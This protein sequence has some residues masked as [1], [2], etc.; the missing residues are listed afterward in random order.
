MHPNLEFDGSKEN[1]KLYAQNDAFKQIELSLHKINN[2][3]LQNSLLE[4]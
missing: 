2:I 3:R 1:V 4:I